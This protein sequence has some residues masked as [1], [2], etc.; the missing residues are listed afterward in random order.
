MKIRQSL[1][2]ALYRAKKDVVGLLMKSVPLVSAR[3]RAL[4][5]YKLGSSAG[6]AGL[7]AAQ[8]KMTRNGAFMGMFAK[9]GS[10]EFVAGNEASTEGE[11]GSL[12][13]VRLKWLLAAFLLPAGFSPAASAQQR[14]IVNP[15]FE[16]GPTLPPSFIITD[17]ANVS[18]W[19]SSNGDIEIWNEGF[20]NRS[21]QDG[22]YLAELNPSAPVALFQEVCLL[23]GETLSWDFYHSARSPA[24]AVQEIEYQVADTSG[25][26]LQ[27]LTSNTVNP[28]GNAADQTDNP[29]VN[30]VG[31]EVY[32]GPTGVHRLQFVSLNAGS[33]GNFLDDI[34]IQLVPLVSV[35]PQNTSAFEGAASPTLPAIVITG[36]LLSDTTVNFST[37]GTA[38]LGA[39]Y[40]LSANTVTI[41]AGTYANDS[42]QFPVTVNTDAVLDDGE[43]IIFTVNSVVAATP[44]TE[45]S[46]TSTVGACDN[47]TLPQATHTILD[48]PPVIDAV[49]DDFASA[50][51]PAAGGTTPSV[52]Q[53]D[54]FNG[55]TPTSATVDVTLTNNGGV[56]GATIAADGTI[57]VPANTPAGPY[58]LTYQI[59][60]AGGTTNCDTATVMIVVAAPPA[61]PEIEI[62]KSVSP[63]SSSI[64]PGDDIT[65]TFIIENTGNVAVEN[66]EPIDTGPTFNS[67][68]G[69]TRAGSNTLSP[70]S[71]VTAA[72]FVDTDANSDLAVD[73]L[74]PGESAQF[75][76]TYEVSEIDLAYMR[77]AADPTT[78]IENSATATGDP[79]S[80]VLPTVAPS[81]VT[82]GVVIP[83]V[84]RPALIPATCG[85]FLS[86]GFTDIIS[87]F[88]ESLIQFGSGLNNDPLT[89][90]NFSRLPSGEVQAF[91]TSTANSLSGD[92]FA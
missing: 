78:A 26:V 25:T 32:T 47:A 69:A 9:P 83:R 27:V 86:E 18:G 44:G 42:F 19:R 22:Q 40:T 34:N 90:M 82:T 52:F 48:T 29:W 6:K 28:I 8:D 50:P 60:E 53:L 75:T 87:G 57:T 59:C 23:N 49:N 14:E 16:D 38:T 67:V 39:D 13:T 68:P 45:P 92:A 46:L 58:T 30:V 20:Q 43:T 17:E 65:Y 12:L 56:A 10:R 33:N 51:I 37:S 15:S 1:F 84:A 88:D 66:V 54:D 5:P 89:Y 24:P 79:V 81:T 76:A 77:N 31:N 35:S 64:Q 4:P 7:D 70:F 11:G 3:C 80:G 55:S 91:Y 73:R 72:G 62:T 2:V 21:A 71:I 61:A 63:I 36:E 74:A 41:P 85:Q